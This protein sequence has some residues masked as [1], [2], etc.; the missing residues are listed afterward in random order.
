MS[1]DVLSTL[2]ERTEDKRKVIQMAAGIPGVFLVCVKV[3][4][5]YFPVIVFNSILVRLQPPDAA[6]VRKPDQQESD[7][8]SQETPF[9]TLT[10]HRRN[11]SAAKMKPQANGESSIHSITQSASRADLNRGSVAGSVR[12]PV[13]TVLP[14]HRLEHFPDRCCTRSYIC[15]YILS[16]P[17]LKVCLSFAQV[18]ST[19]ACFSRASAFLRRVTCM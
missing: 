15:F 17:I 16:Q 2:K 11:G 19:L 14:K 6:A 5:Q 4:F 12:S 10:P 18:C 7:I 1:F 3:Y 9:H 13:L 8:T